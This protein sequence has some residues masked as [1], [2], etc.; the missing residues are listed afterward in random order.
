MRKLLIAFILLVGAC[1]VDRRTS[2]VASVGFESQQKRQ[3]ISKT[4]RLLRY[5]ADVSLDEMTLLEPKTRDELV[6]LFMKDAAFA[7]TLLD[8][9]LFFLGAKNDALYTVNSDGTRSYNFQ[10]FSVDESSYVQD[11]FYPALSS[12][13]ETYR[14]G[15]FLDLIGPDFKFYW[16]MNTPPADLSVERFTRV[17]AFEAEFNALVGTGAT[18]PALCAK[19]KEYL[20]ITSTGQSLDPSASATLGLALTRQRFSGACA[21]SA[22]VLADVIKTTGD[23]IAVLH[24]IDK[25]L[26]RGA[27]TA[28]VHSLLDYYGLKVDADHSNLFFSNYFWTVAK[29]SSTNFN[30]RRAARVLRTYFCDDLTPLDVVQQDGDFT[31]SAHASKKDCQA[32]HYRLDP[33]AGFFRDRGYGGNVATN[34]ITFDDFKTL[35]GDQLATYLNTW[36]APAGSNHDFAVGFIRA[37]PDSGFVSLNSYGSTL[38]DLVGII[39]TAP[40]VRQCVVK[41]L[42]EYVIG[43]SQSYDEGWIESLKKDLETAP[44][45]GVGVKAVMKKLVLSK[46][47]S[48]QDPDPSACY[49]LAPGAQ[50]S[51]LPCRVSFILTKY[52]VTCHKGAG[53]EKGLDLAS[54]TEG[55]DGKGAFTHVRDG[56]A[57]QRQETF[58]LIKA[59]ISSDDKDVIM[60]PNKFMSSAD[61][62]ELFKWAY[63]QNN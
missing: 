62:T 22:P 26:V 40:E 28:G 45:S 50:P 15:E 20:D 5:G 60:P 16:P 36:K 2:Q 44:T 61:K 41:R 38:K 7:D 9:N 23:F 8:F 59:R 6:D 57:V 29:N 27:A 3:W 31:E 25:Y 19:I 49:D 51:Q 18:A 14:D 1:A 53:A 37:K 30:R 47:F 32:C 58:N 33:M 4:A 48:Q 55:A 39:R 52:C 11:P 10:S 21:A 17:T 42:A 13:I 24:A 63:G 12:A 54:W 34:S 56:V 35:T 43:P 46:T